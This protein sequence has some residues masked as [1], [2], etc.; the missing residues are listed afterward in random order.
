M[1]DKVWTS[2]FRFA[3]SFFD[4]FEASTAYYYHSRI[5]VATSIDACTLWSHIEMC[6]TLLFD[7]KG[8]K[9]C[10][11]FNFPACSWILLCRSEH[12]SWLCFCSLFR[13]AAAVSLWSWSCSWSESRSRQE[14]SR[15]TFLNNTSIMTIHQVHT[16]PTHLELFNNW[17]LCCYFI[18]EVWQ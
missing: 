16:Q 11:S 13:D 5:S 9:M 4:F 18:T 8:N 12:L 2:A 14:W 3:V 10:T 17:W 15:S 1:S 6:W 7:T